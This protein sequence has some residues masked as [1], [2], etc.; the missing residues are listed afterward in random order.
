[1]HSP[2]LTP[3]AAAWWLQIKGVGFVYSVRP[4]TTPRFAEG[5]YGDRMKNIPTGSL[6]SQSM[7]HFPK[8]YKYSTNAMSR[9]V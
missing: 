2:F 4:T 3:Y 7:G 8:E 9:I 6:I 1:M 5:A